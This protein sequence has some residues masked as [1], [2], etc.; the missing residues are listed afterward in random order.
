MSR[1]VKIPWPIPVIWTQ[2]AH[3]LITVS[4]SHSNIQLDKE[5]T[6][7][8]LDTTDSPVSRK[9]AIG[10]T[11]PV[12]TQVRSFAVKESYGFLQKHF[13][14]VLCPVKPKNEKGNY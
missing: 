2:L 10:S 3:Q 4:Y 8:T 5:Y 1:I 6:W 7:I 13:S 11:E 12:L 14:K 9:S